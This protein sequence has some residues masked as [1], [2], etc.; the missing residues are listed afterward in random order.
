[1]EWGVAEPEVSEQVSTT[2]VIARISPSAI[3]RPA[4]IQTRERA[5][6]TRQAHK[7]QPERGPD[8]EP[9]ARA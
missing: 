9:V 1:M 6:T 4:S 8:C 5:H 7:D 3:G 2:I